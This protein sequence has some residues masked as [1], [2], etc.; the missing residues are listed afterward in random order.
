V[1]RIIT[2]YPNERF[3]AIRRERFET[4]F[5]RRIFRMC[6][7]VARSR[8]KGGGNMQREQAVVVCPNCEKSFKVLADEV[9]QNME[10][11]QCGYLSEGKEK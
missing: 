6:G 1:A 11:L 8:G 3:P 4:N 2:G 5:W 7:S 10:C 9:Y